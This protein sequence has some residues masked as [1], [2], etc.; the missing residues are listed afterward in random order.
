[1]VDVKREYA[2]YLKYAQY[3]LLSAA[4][5]TTPDKKH[6]RYCM[7]V[8]ASVCLWISFEQQQKFAEPDIILHELKSAIS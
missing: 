6:S 5:C 2:E 7:A 8:H 4:P 3:D 1:V